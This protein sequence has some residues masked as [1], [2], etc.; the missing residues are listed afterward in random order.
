MYHIAIM[1]QCFP[2]HGRPRPRDYKGEMVNAYL[3]ATCDLMCREILLQEEMMLRIKLVKVKDQVLGGRSLPKQA[4]WTRPAKGK[5]QFL[6]TS[7]RALKNFGLWSIP[8]A[9][10]EPSSTEDHKAACNRTNNTCLVKN[11]PTAGNTG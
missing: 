5:H 3:S 4:D 7:T 8:Q 6:S 11:P 10:A 2:K 1:P 9:F